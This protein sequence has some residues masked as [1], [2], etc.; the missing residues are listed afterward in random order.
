MWQQRLAGERDD[1]ML[2]QW[3]P[4]SAASQ[5]SLGLLLAYSLLGPQSSGLPQTPL[6]ARGP[7][8]GHSC[9]VEARVEFIEDIF[10]L[11]WS[12][13]TRQSTKLP[14]GSHSHISRLLIPTIG[15][16]QRT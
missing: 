14:P 4:Q 12:S 7:S 13:T 11:L 6:Q 10:H 5:G 15:Q 9:E 16:A 1:P 2:G 8:Q 3:A